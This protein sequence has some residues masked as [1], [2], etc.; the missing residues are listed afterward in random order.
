MAL[1]IIAVMEVGADTDVLDASVSQALTG[2][3]A[4]VAVCYRGA[5]R[6]GEQLATM[7]RRGAPIVIF[8]ESAVERDPRRLDAVC[9]NVYRHFRPDRLLLLDSPASRSDA[10]VG[11]SAEEPLP[12]PGISLDADRTFWSDRALVSTS[13]P[14]TAPEPGFGVLGPSFHLA[15]FYLDL[16]PFRHVARKYA[17]ESVLDVGCGLGGYV[18]AFR[19]WGARDVQ[20]VDGF[21]DHGEVLCGDVYRCHD[22]R[23][24]LDLG[25]TFELVIS[26]EVI[27]H[28][29]AGH[30]DVLLDT[31]RRHARD[32]ILFSG[33]VPDQ[34][35]VGHVNCRPMDYWLAA[36]ER[37]GWEPDVLDSI[38]VR[39]L[40]TYH[41]FRRNLLVLRP[42]SRGG[43]SIGFDLSD[44]VSREA[45]A[46]PWTAQPP[47]I[48][49]YPLGEPLPNMPPAE[50]VGS[51]DG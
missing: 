22:L 2:C 6:A 24:P 31:I 42:R 9:R 8:D 4:L 36:W 3:D 30:E 47:A 25:R 5:R 51:R 45:V 38:A 43:G 33:A 11:A 15:E 49:V 50:A 39:S 7:M 32:V 26:T 10:P 1:R 34:P 19:R 17:P 35:G 44:L 41:W 14:V 13:A 28:V 29:P 21:A 23:Q 16:P 46:A 20:G 12:A 27:E 37:L 40:G 48:H 18:V